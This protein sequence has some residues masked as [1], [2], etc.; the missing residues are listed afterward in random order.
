MQNHSSTR[1]HSAASR[2]SSA[3]KSSNRLQHNYA[4]QVYEGA[5]ETV[6]E[7]PLSSVLITM[8]LGFGAGMLL[9]ALIAPPPRRKTYL[10]Q[11]GNRVE[12]L[13]HRVLDAVSGYLPRSSRW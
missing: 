7:Y 1:N 3:A 10:E 12:E 4:G 2:S 6:S 9:A 13:G 11:A 5:Q 8:G